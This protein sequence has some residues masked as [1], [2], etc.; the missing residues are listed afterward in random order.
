MDIIDVLLEDHAALRG[1]AEALTSPHTRARGGAPPD[2]KRLLGDMRA[3]FTLF[4]A[5]EAVEDDFLSEA[6]CLV[7]LDAGQRAEFS[8]TRRALAEALK[9]F[10]AFAVGSGGKSVEPM[11]DVA[12]RLRDD[13]EAHLSCEE[14]VVFPRLRASMR[15]AK[16]R[17]LGA[18]ARAGARRGSG[19][20][21]K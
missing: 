17:D 18:R 14:R 5:H 10:G 11:R 2:R 13:L 20:S 3:F 16:L 4:K 12:L 9:K 6:F 21:A 7:E 19:V 15:A 8:E 1:E